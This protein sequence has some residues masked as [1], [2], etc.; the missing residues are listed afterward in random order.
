[1][2][3]FVN[4]LTLGGLPDVV[5]LEGATHFV[6][7]RVTQPPLTIDLERERP[8][9]SVELNILTIHQLDSGRW[10]AEG[11]TPHS[12]VRSF[13][14]L[15]PREAI[16]R[17]I[18]AGYGDRFPADFVRELMSPPVE[19]RG[20][21]QPP[22]VLG[23]PK[24]PLT[25]VAYQIVWMMLR[26]GDRGIRAADLE[27]KHG[28]ARTVV[29]KLIRSDPEGWGKVIRR[30]RGLYGRYYITRPYSSP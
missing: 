5:D 29:R 17:L 3:K 25:K 2:A 1:M 16:P 8:K 20:E 4:V 10:I 28:G 27:K 23:I 19:L 30:D 14:E 12:R 24:P 6:I 22:L 26:A 15:F 21:G 11:S 13:A 18:A 9:Q 7:P